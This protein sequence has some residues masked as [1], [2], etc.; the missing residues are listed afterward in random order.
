MAI[1]G[2][3]SSTQENA[4]KVLAGIRSTGY[5]SEPARLSPGLTFREC[6]PTGVNLQAAKATQ[7]T[8]LNPW[9]TRRPGGK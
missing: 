9:V 1:P 4:N 7:G 8:M 6:P 3:P 5:P 2:I